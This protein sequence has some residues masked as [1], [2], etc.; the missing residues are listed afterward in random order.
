M[1]KA[2]VMADTLSELNP[3]VHPNPIRQRLRAQNAIDLLSGHDVVLDGVDDF[4][5]RFVINKACLALGIPL[6]SG[7]LGRFDGQVSLFPNDGEG[8]CY[9]C[10]VPHI[11]PDAETCAQVGVMGALAGLVGSLMAME[12]VKHITGAGETLSG[13]LWLYDGLKAESRTITLAKDPNCLAC[14]V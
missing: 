7:A 6:V 14:S 9:R 10:L 2:T 13:R 3:D 11:P 1:P 12:V 8:P 4:A 5:T